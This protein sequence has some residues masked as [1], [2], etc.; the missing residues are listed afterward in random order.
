MPQLCEL[1]FILNYFK[2]FGKKVLWF[3]NV[4]LNVQHLLHD[5]NT[6]YG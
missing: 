5:V 6:F 3:V 4:L 1:R 2:W